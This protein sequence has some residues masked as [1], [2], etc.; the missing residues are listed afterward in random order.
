MYAC[1]CVPNVSHA[2]SGATLD[3]CIMYCETAGKYDLSEGIDECGCAAPVGRVACKGHEE[4]S[5]D[6]DSVGPVC[7]H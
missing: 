6:V 3:V 5:R 1:A 7:S 4:A 2:V